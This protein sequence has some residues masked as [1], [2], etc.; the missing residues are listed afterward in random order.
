M[1]SQK[2]KH[3]QPNLS[4]L[5]IYS[6]PHRSRVLSAQ[7]RV[8]PRGRLTGTILYN[9]QSGCM[10]CMQCARCFTVR[11]KL[12]THKISYG[13]TGQGWRHG[14]LLKSPN[15]SPCT[16]GIV[17]GVILNYNRLFSTI[18]HHHHTMLCFGNTQALSTLSYLPIKYLPTWEIQVYIL[19]KYSVSYLFHRYLGTQFIFQGQGSTLLFQF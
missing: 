8:A 18:C 5:K 9:G 4:N 15:K 7:T 6:A 16:N 3:K 10:L 14:P 12:P 13:P 2:L 19:R 11:V 17:I 1:L